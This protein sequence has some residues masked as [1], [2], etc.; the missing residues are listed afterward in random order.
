MLWRIKGLVLE[1]LAPEITIQEFQILQHEPMPH[2]LARVSHLGFAHVAQVRNET[3]GTKL[4][5]RTFLVARQTSNHKTLSPTCKLWTAGTP[6]A[7]IQF[8]FLAREQQIKFETM[9][10]ETHIAVHICDKCNIQ[11]H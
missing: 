9:V 7:F 10:Q 3:I 4:A 6:A 8:G 2:G 1:S 5:R 11:L